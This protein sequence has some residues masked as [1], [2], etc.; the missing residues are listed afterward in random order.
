ML[1][2]CE[3]FDCFVSLLYCGFVSF[4]VLTTNDQRLV[5]LRAQKLCWNDN[6]RRQACGRSWD[7]TRPREITWTFWKC[8]IHRECHRNQC[9]LG[10]CKYERK[11]TQHSTHMRRTN[12]SRR[13]KYQTIEETVGHANEQRFNRSRHRGSIA[14]LRTTAGKQV[15]R[16]K[17]SGTSASGRGT[18]PLPDRGAHA[19]L[20]AADGSRATGRHVLKAVPTSLPSTRSGLG[21]WRRM[22]D[23]ANN[24]SNASVG[25]FVCFF[26]EEKRPWPWS[27]L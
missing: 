5:E 26:F 3:V 16:A 19:W 4:V 25:G 8:G 2:R 6:R 10:F 17:N 24:S 11:Q 9:L 1:S 27:N 15:Q 20:V 22:A 21:C 23:N 18:L 14:N 13:E 7:R 12:C